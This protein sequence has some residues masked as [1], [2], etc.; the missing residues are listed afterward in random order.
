MD[1]SV[2]VAVLGLILPVLTLGF[3]LALIVAYRRRVTGVKMPG[4]E[5]TLKSDVDD[6]V[7][8]RA[9]QKGGDPVVPWWVGTAVTDRAQRIADLLA[10]SAVLWHDPDPVNSFPERTVLER[11]G[12][13][14][15]P[16]AT[17]REA[18]E[19]L[20][21][22]TNRRIYDVIVSNVGQDKVGLRFRDALMDRS[23]Y[24]PLIFYVSHSRPN[25]AVPK[26]AFAITDQPDQFF[27]LVMDVIE[28]RKPAA[29]SKP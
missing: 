22:S 12:M 20:E 8:Q 29:S 4:F 14:V 7:K 27:H 10:T 24:P 13:L 6:L 19:A 1:N 11:F 16:V 18:I 21:P 28:R 17:I 25:A 5:L 23:D 2:L 26:G 9:A 3:F 15:K